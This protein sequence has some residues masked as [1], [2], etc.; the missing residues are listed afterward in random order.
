MMKLMDANS[1]GLKN[2]EDLQLD[3]KYEVTY[4]EVTNEPTVTLLEREEDQ[5]AF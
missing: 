2:I 1:K 3:N 4:D 5:K